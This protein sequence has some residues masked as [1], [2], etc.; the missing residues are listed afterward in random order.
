MWE[1]IS[2]NKKKSMWLF[3]GMALCLVVLGFFIGAAIDPERGGLVGLMLAVGLWM[4]LS[5]VTISSGRDILL[6]VDGGVKKNNIGEYAK[7]GADMYV[8][9]SALFAGAIDE[10]VLF[11]LDALRS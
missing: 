1:L 5:L 7:M 9:G 3:A 8:S 11:M 6:C 10:N 4:V 2:A